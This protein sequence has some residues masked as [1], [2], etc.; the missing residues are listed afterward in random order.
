ML[1]DPVIVIAQIINFVV[2]VALLKRF[3]Y[4]PITNAMEARSQ[5]IERELAA[6]ATK[7][8]D[9]EAEKKL[10]L[11]KQQE[12]EAQKQQW[13]DQAKQEVALEKAKLTQQVQAELEQMRFQWYQAFEQDRHKF[14]RELRNSISNQVIL[15]TRKVLFDLANANLEAQIIETFIERLYSSNELQTQKIADAPISKTHNVIVIR[16]SFPIPDAQKSRLITAIK[17]QIT[18]DAEVKLEVVTDL[19]C[20]IELRYRGYK[21]S[22]NLEAYLAELEVK[23]AKLL[24]ENNHQ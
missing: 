19:I 4:K 13:L 6:A 8:K 24:A 12:L 5:R 21:I 7:E 11:H 18:T 16:S 22:W 23:T 2:L 15:T 1:I 14:S 9:A 20:G 10:Y 17:E 3:L